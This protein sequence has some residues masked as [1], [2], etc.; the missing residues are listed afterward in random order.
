M[1]KSNTEISAPARLVDDGSGWQT[2]TVLSQALVSYVA[3]EL[4]NAFTNDA[5]EPSVIDEAIRRGFTRLDDDIVQ[6]ALRSISSAATRAEIIADIAPAVSGSMAVL[7]IYDPELSILRVASVGDS[8]AVLGQLSGGNSANGTWNALALSTPQTPVREDELAILLKEHPDEPEMIAN[9][10]LLG[11]PVT[12]AF[13]DHRWKWPAEAI[14]EGRKKYYAFEA[15]P[16]FKSPPYLHAT[17]EI[18]TTVVKPGD[19]AILGTDGLW[20]TMSAENAIRCMS[21]WIH[22]TNRRVDEGEEYLGKLSDAHAESIPV[23]EEEQETR[24]GETWSWIARPEDFVCEDANAATHLIRNALG[25]NRR[26]QFCTLMGV[27]PPSTDD[28]RDDMT[29]QVIFFGDVVKGCA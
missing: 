6:G 11:I 5:K 23:M 25:G 7:A 10:R 13:G 12:R 29:V 16:N 21:M 20:D 26:E 8:R 9:K 17:P 22:E 15:R 14:A 4:K 1:R 18:S 24:V 27:L 2:S 3:R 28:A 19:F